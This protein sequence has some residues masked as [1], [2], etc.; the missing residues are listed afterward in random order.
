MAR[1][2]I[3]EDWLHT[4]RIIETLANIN[5]D[6]KKRRKPYTWKDFHPM[7]VAKRKGK[8]N[9]VSIGD[10]LTAW[11]LKKKPGE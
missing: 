11:G 2:R 6:P 8:D 9:R 3:K 7:W 5:R 10:V 1:A 4:S